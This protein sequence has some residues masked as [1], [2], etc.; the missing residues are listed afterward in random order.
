MAAN[1]QFVIVGHVVNFEPGAQYTLT[2]FATLQVDESLKGSPGTTVRVPIEV[3]LSELR[4]WK[5]RNTSLLIAG[6]ASYVPRLPIELDSPSLCFSRA[7]FSLVRNSRDLLQTLRSFL[8]QHPEQT[9]CVIRHAPNNRLGAAWKNEITGQGY[10]EDG[11]YVPLGVTQIREIRRLLSSNRATEVS[12][13]LGLVQADHTRET[14][15]LVK[16]VRKLPLF[17]VQKAARYNQGYELRY[18]YLRMTAERLLTEWG[19]KF[20]PM[21]T[22][23]M[24]D[25]A[26]EVTE[27]EWDPLATDATPDRLAKFSKLTSLAFYVGRTKD[28]HLRVLAS[29]PPITKLKLTQTEWITD[30]CWPYLKNLPHLE[31]LDLTDTNVTDTSIPFLAEM[32]GLRTVHLDGTRFTNAGLQKLAEIRPGLRITPDVEATT[33]LVI[34]EMNQMHL[35][36]AVK[37]ITSDPTALQQK[38]FRGA[39]P[40]H[41]ACGWRKL[42]YV[43]ALLNEHADVNA[44][45][46]EGKTPLLWVCGIYLSENMLD[47][48]TLLLRYGAKVDAVDQDGNDPLLTAAN[49]GAWG[50]VE[51][52]L[53][54]GANP[55]HRNK[56]GKTLLD[57]VFQPDGYHRKLVEQAIADWMKSHPGA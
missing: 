21:P 8:K 1:S 47:T 33:T 20:E 45:D 24:V 40:L 4:I 56:K 42:D 43:Q 44:V 51:I 55:T 30:G 37:A 22:E 6:S 17:S 32:K 39:T 18:Y 31:E 11:L 25:H 54:A 14:E 28:E 10:K 7:D 35:G 53:K 57:S 12:D 49:H 16:G 26:H 9:R 29:A 3:K 50:A 38:D 48:I 27:L 36:R 41:V 23:E 5:A 15:R 13:G 2:N 34:Y 46:K 19:T 52:L